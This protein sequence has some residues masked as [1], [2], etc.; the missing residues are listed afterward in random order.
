MLKDL[1]F[2]VE[3]YVAS[4]VCEDS[5]A[6]ATVNHDGKIIPVGDARLITEELVRSLTL[7][8][9]ILLFTLSVVS[10]LKMPY[11]S[12]DVT[13]MTVR[14]TLNKPAH[15][16]SLTSSSSGVRLIC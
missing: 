14:S 2:K 15:C 5:I 7:P 3:K 10:L 4:E 8:I 13:E 6:V 16:T 1:G 11:S 9:S 12:S